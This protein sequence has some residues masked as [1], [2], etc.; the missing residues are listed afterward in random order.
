MSWRIC[1]AGSS[2]LSQYGLVRANLLERGDAFGRHRMRLHVGVGAVRGEQAVIGEPLEG[3]VHALR[4]LAGGVEEL[5]RG[6]IGVFLLLALIGQ[7]RAADDFLRRADRGRAGID[8]AIVAAAAFGARHHRAG[9]DQH[10]DDHLGLCPCQL[11]MHLGEMAAGEMA[12]FMRQ[13]PDDLVRC[14]GLHQGAVVHENAVAVGDEGVEGAVIDDHNLDVLLLKARG[15][16]DRP[17]VVAQQL[18]AL[19][20]TEDLRPVSLLGEGRQRG[21]GERRGGG[22]GGQ[23]PHFSSCDQ[24]ERHLGFISI[25]GGA[26]TGYALTSCGMRP[27]WGVWKDS[28][29]RCLKRH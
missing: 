16:Q 1:R 19:G 13:H 17:G 4:R 28:R 27:V 7:Q 23:F 24:A 2:F 15:A 5:H 6:A 29:Y 10:G 18:L 11:L 12:G 8:Q 25:G 26:V 14:L 21:H 20:I 22:D 3:F 9:T